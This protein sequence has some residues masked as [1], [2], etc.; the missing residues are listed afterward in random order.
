MQLNIFGGVGAMKKGEVKSSRVHNHVV[1]NSNVIWNFYL[2]GVCTHKCSRYDWVFFSLPPVGDA[3]LL[4]RYV[5]LRNV[6]VERST[7]AA[8]IPPP[9]RERDFFKCSNKL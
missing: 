5:L 1:S 7:D 6:P 2:E 4:P 9:P 3:S 8:Y